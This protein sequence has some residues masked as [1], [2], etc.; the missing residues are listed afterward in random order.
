[1]HVLVGIGDRDN[2][3]GV[4]LFNKPS[5]PSDPGWHS[6]RLQ[7]FSSTLCSLLCLPDTQ[8]QSGRLEQH[9]VYH[10]T[11]VL[12]ECHHCNNGDITSHSHEVHQR[13]RRHLQPWILACKFTAPWVVVHTQGACIYCHAPIIFKTLTS[14]LYI[15]GFIIQR[16]R[17]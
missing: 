9:K 12:Y 1:M 17:W 4:Y 11:R 3:T 2:F 5:H 15:D 10:C 13:L 7:R 6:S 14:R 16:P 8:G